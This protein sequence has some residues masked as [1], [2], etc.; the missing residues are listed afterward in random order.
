M[1]SKFTLV[2]SLPLVLNLSLFVTCVFCLKMPLLFF[3]PRIIHLYHKTGVNNLQHFFQLHD[4]FIVQ[5][6]FICSFQGTDVLTSLTSV[7]HD[8]KESPPQKYLNL[9]TSWMRV[10]TL[11]RLTTSWLS[12]QVI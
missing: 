7:L 4:F 11:R 5:F 8:D 12:Q 10:E 2:T 1:L 9:T 6:I 3:G